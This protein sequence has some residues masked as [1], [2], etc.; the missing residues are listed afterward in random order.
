MSDVRAAVRDFIL[1]NCL[2]GES[3]ENLHDDMELRTTG[4]LDSM[5]VL[6]LVSLIEETEKF[7][8]EAHEVDDENF[9]S[10][11]GIVAFVER[12]RGAP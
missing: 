8:I 12:R 3:P 9:R 4:I 5:S 11:D 2:P 1:T 7:E 10:V 6:K